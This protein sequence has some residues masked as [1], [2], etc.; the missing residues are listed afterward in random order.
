MQRAGE[1][2]GAAARAAATEFLDSTAEVPDDGDDLESYLILTDGAR[3]WESSDLEE[4][5]SAD[6]SD[7]TWLRLQAAI[8]SAGL[9]GSS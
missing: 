2:F 7:P 4:V 3:T 1:G 9:A 6:D 5:T 8:N